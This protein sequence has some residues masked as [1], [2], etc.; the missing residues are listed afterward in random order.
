[1]T[2]D[3]EAVKKAYPNAVNI[4]SKYGAKDKDGNRISIASTLVDAARVELDKLSYKTDRVVGLN[5]ITYPSLGEQL[6]LLYHDIKAGKLGIAA[7][8]GEWFV[9]IT[10]VKDAHP[11]PS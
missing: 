2:Y 8:T 7:T 5:T 3:V 10:S 6:D 11:K 9:G 4:C 1:M